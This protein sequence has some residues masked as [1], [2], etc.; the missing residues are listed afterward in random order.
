MDLIHGAG[1]NFQRCNNMGILVLS[2]KSKVN[3]ATYSARLDKVSSYNTKT[4]DLTICIIN[5]LR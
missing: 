1:R 3:K 2:C 4:K 5:Q